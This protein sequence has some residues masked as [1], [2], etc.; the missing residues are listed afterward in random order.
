MSAR[1]PHGPGFSLGPTEAVYRAE[2][3][4]E[5]W[6]EGELLPWGPLRLDPAAACLS[7]GL[8][9]FEGLKAQRGVDG[10]LRLFRPADN[11]ARFGRSAAQLLMPPFPAPRFVDAVA[12]VV[13]ANAAHAPPAGTGA[14]Y[15]RPIQIASEPR[16]GAGPCQRVT[17]SIYASPV[18]AYFAGDDG[19]RLRALRQARVPAG[20]CGSAK[21]MGNYA[22]CL[23]TV[24]SFRARGYDDVLFLDAAER[25]LVTETSGANVFARLGDGPLVTPPLDDQVLPGIT[26]DSVIRIA[27]EVLDLEVEERPLALDE[28]LGGASE[29]FCTGTAYTVRPARELSFE[30]RELRLPS[31]ATA[32]AL[33]E[34]LLGIQLGDGEDP[35]GWTVEL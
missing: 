9:V 30:D 6:G 18:G 5:A 2:G 27:R 19:L 23:A 34:L 32:D 24:H 20:G 13:R 1:D 21:A 35:F 25:R 12:R 15:V 26:R 7:Y 16:L 10:G 33:R 17:V 28:V 11:A 22:G 8:G 14:L 29:L 4:G 31:R 3:E